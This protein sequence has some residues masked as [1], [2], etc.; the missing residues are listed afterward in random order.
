MA[1]MACMACIACVLGVMFARYA[2][3]IELDGKGGEEGYPRL[4][5]ISGVIKFV[6][7]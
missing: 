4:L 7:N 1:C 5:Y 3:C 6:K 2:L